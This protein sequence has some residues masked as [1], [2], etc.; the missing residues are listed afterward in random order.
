LIV[1]TAMLA[2]ERK[3]PWWSVGLVLVSSL[4]PPLVTLDLIPLSAVG[5][6]VALIPLWGRLERQESMQVVGRE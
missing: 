6:L 4:L 5:Y 1:L 2:H 3:L